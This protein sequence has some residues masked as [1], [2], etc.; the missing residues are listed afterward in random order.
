MW[1][2][3]AGCLKML[4]RRQLYGIVLQSLSWFFFLNDR[5]SDSTPFWFLPFQC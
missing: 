1:L 5:L 2:R 3:G 4:E